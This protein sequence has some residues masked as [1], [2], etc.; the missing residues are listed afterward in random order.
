LNTVLWW[1][2]WLLILPGAWAAWYLALVVG[3][4]AHAALEAF[5]PRS[6]MI[7]GACM[8][9]WFASVSRVVICAGAGLA[10][11]LLLVTCAV[12]A[13]GH[14]A[15]VVMI[16]LVAGVLTALTM[17]IVVEAYPEC[18]TAVVVGGLVATWLR[19]SAWVRA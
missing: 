6:Q 14:R 15:Q 16:T 3:L 9:P 11:A 4:A 8:A 5:C 12:I 18:I 7:S 2:R 1:L 10:A 19:K 17:G 13:P